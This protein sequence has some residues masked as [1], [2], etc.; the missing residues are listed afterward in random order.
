MKKKLIAIMLCIVTA[1]SFAQADLTSLS[2]KYYAA[3]GL[4]FENMM[5]LKKKQKD[6][7][8]LTFVGEA[9]GKIENKLSIKWKGGEIQNYLNEKL[10]NSK[11]LVWFGTGGD[12]TFIKLDEGVIAIVSIG[13]DGTKVGDVLAKDASKLKDFDF[14]TVKALVDAMAGDKNAE[15]NEALLKKMMKYDAFK[16]NLEKVVFGDNR[17]TFYND[18][19]EPKEDPKTHI[20]SQILGKAVYYN[21]YTATNP[22]A[23]YAASAEY[24][25]EFEMEGVKKDRKSCSKLGRNWAE[26]FQKLEVKSRHLFLSGRTFCDPAQKIYDYAFLSLMNDLS[27]KLLMGKTYNLKVTVYVYKDGANVATL[28]TGIIALKYEPESKAQMDLWVEWISQM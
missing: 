18:Y 21:C 16:N 28:G 8:E 22:E 15:A 19:G 4:E 13:S 1:T 5:K 12:N 3:D 2:G 27:G 10:F 11:K 6:G 14:E 17:N 24:N 7:I 26:S 20:K 25:I 23:K 9:K